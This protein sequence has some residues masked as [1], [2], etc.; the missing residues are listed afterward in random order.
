MMEADAVPPRPLLA[1]GDRIS[2]Y[3]RRVGRA[4]QLEPWP[5]DPDGA[6]LHLHVET[7]EADLALDYW[8]RQIRDPEAWWMAVDHV[9]AR[10]PTRFALRTARLFPGE[11]EGALR[12]IEHLVIAQAV[13]VGRDL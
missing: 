5:L 3:L 7:P 8:L 13:V 10:E 2:D 6:G 1:L 9:A 4:H 12:R 11:S